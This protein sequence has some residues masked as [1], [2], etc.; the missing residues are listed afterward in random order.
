MKPARPFLA[1]PCLL[2]LAGCHFGQLPDPNDPNGRNVVQPDVLRNNLM[3]AAQSIFD[4]VGRGEIS[5]RRGQELLSKYAN[6]LVDS[7]HV[8]RIPPDRAWEYAEVFRAAKRW[9]EAERFLEIAVKHAPNED[10]RVNDSL[11]LAQAM[12]YLHEVPQAIPIVRSTFTT[13]PPNKAPILISV[14]LEFTPAAQGQGH[15][16]EVASVLEDAIPQAWQTVVNPNTEPG[17]AFLLARPHHTQNAWAKVIE[18]YQS[19]GRPDLA[20]EAAKRSAEFDR[21]HSQV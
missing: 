16:A 21:A 10:R 11:R 9:K 7:I 17:A 6:Q 2:L 1:V 19:A 4:R 18:L 8:E 12:A 20:R 14:L 5:D 13:T 15:D 3:S